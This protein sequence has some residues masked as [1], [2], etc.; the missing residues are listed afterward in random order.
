MSRLP[1]FC[2][3]GHCQHL[4]QR[5]NNRQVC[6][7]SEEDFAAYA[8]WLRE[9][10]QQFTVAIHAWVFMTNHVHLLATPTKD[11]GISLMMQSLGRRYVRYFNH[12]H[13]RTGTLWEGR[14]KSFLVEGD[15]YALVCQRY[16]ELNPVRAGMVVDA[17]QYVW[18]SYRCSA[19]GR[20]SFLWTPHPSYQALGETSPQ[21]Q[22]AHRKLV[23]RALDAKLL[24]EIRRCVSSG[25]ALGRQ[26][27]KDQVEAIY[28]RRVNE[29]RRGRPPAKMSS[30][31]I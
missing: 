26:N 27:F 11:N 19:M 15:P 29:G 7:S 17:S 24:R 5:G 22:A 10:S 1:R 31:P 20:R 18:S 2:P 28:G 4:I 13:Q 6:F 3:A 8:H 12:R 9:Y 23:K 25:L 21:R 16:I 30:D 14:F